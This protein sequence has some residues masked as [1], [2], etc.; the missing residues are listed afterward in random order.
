MKSKVCCEMSNY[1]G[2]L[3]W[4]MYYRIVQKYFTQRKKRTHG[5]RFF[6]GQGF[7]INQKDFLLDLVE[8]MPELV[9]DSK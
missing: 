9:W 2:N 6:Y 4:V 3:R 7:E 1:K 8:R 5:V